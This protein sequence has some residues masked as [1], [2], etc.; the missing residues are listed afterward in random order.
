MVLKG[1][2]PSVAWGCDPI[3]LPCLLVISLVTFFL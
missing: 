3:H 2:Q 1:P